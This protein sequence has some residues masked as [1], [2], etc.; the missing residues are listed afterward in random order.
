[1]AVIVTQTADNAYHIQA[2]F[3][4]MKRDRYPMGLY[5]AI[6]ELINDITPEGEY[7]HFDVF[8]WCCNISELALSNFIF[9]KLDELVNYISD[10]T[11]V[12]YVDEVN[13]TVYYLAH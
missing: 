1:M 2:A 9:D 10:G 4:E 7:Y 8:A 3:R 12:L 6:F 11:T 13:E 5:E